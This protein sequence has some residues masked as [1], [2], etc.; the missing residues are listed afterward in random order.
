MWYSING[1]ASGIRSTFSSG[2]TG[3]I[4]QLQIYLKRRNF[5]PTSLRWFVPILILLVILYA[6]VPILM[7]VNPEFLRNV[8]VRSQPAI[9]N[10]DIKFVV[11][12]VG[13]FVAGIHALFIGLS[14]WLT[15]MIFKRRNWARIV[16]TFLLVIATLGSFASWTAGPAFY[17][18]II[19]TNIV[20][21]ILVGL[22][23]IPRSV[24]NFFTN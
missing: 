24:S 2:S 6:V 21:T 9:S 23:W 22:L 20:H 19:A 8:I 12:I 13:I 1:R 7:I 17:G 3:R 16:L 11:N 4:A 5:M 18:I 10:K 15:T 14:I